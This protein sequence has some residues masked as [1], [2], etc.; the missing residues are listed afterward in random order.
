METRLHCIQTTSRHMIE[1]SR[2]RIAPRPSRTGL[3]NIFAHW[4]P[5]KESNLKYSSK[6]IKINCSDKNSIF[7]NGSQYKNQT[8]RIPKSPAIRIR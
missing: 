5:G 3:K 4:I 7:K 2:Y 1:T 6:I 8:F